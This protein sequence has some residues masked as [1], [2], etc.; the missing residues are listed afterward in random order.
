M[1]YEEIRKKISEDSTIQGRFLVTAEISYIISLLK[2]K[3]I[4]T[5]EDEKARDI[6]VK[7]MVSQL[8]EETIQ[9][10]LENENKRDMELDWD[11][12]LEHLTEMLAEAITIGPA[13]TFYIMGCNMLKNRYD[14]GER[15]K[16]LYDEIMDLH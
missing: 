11:K 2:S 6:Y 9:E 1:E 3:G 12:A 13:G 15:T 5:E 4:M 16:E 7:G 8:T 10:I 14:N